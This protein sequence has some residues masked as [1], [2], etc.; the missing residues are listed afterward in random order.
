MVWRLGCSQF[1]LLSATLSIGLAVS[2]PTQAQAQ[3]NSSSLSSSLPNQ[4]EFRA[5]QGPAADAPENTHGGAT[6]GPA[7]PEPEPSL[8]ELYELTAEE[9]APEKQ[10]VEPLT[11]NSQASPSIRQVEVGVGVQIGE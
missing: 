11:T 1:A 3:V 4:W 10:F 8:Y 5:P 7:E 6:R 2:I 9:V